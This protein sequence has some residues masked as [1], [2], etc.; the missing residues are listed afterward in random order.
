MEDNVF[1]SDRP[2]RVYGYL[3]SHDQLLLR[4]DKIKGYEQNIDIVFFGVSY[5]QLHTVLP[6]LTIR[7]IDRNTEVLHE[8]V[9]NEVGWEANN[10][11]E[12]ISGNEK[13]KIVAFFVR[14]FEN[15]LESGESSLGFSE[16]GREKE[17]ARID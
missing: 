12:V 8:S 6:G 5:I 4:S 10:L 17:I 2:F 16:R 13:Y 7:K 3:V 15:D 14:V 11:F 9:K 1:A